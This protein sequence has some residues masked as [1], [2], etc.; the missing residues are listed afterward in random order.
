MVEGR[1]FRRMWYREDEP[2]V[3]DGAR[4]A[5]RRASGSAPK[6]VIGHTGS[7]GYEEEVY[8]HDHP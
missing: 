7:T 6:D 1:C 2:S 3:A 5:G 8:F 4:L